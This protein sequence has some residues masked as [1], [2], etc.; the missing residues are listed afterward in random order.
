MGTKKHAII[1][2]SDKSV[3]GRVLPGAEVEALKKSGGEAIPET[4]K[5][6]LEAELGADFS[7]VKIHTDE[8][9]F[10]LSNTLQATAFTI[11]N[12]VFIKPGSYN[13]HTESGRSLIAHELS[14][15]VQ[16]RSGSTK[17]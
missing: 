5:K 3:D 16:Q 11:G 9:A 10:R 4:V 1:K 2:S 14:H 13:P 15:V 6:K 12:D 17:K 7:A 8:H